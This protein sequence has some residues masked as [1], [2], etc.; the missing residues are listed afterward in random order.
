[1]G[2]N[3]S[4]RK[5]KGEETGA[6]CPEIETWMA[7]AVTESLPNLK[8][9]NPSKRVN[10]MEPCIHAASK[11]T[12]R[13]NPC[14]VVKRMEATPSSSRSSPHPQTLWTVAFRETR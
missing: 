14:V 10:A 6:I 2:A 5:R 9:G 12:E 4:R 3:R 7:V 8:T 13:Q 11:A 1:M